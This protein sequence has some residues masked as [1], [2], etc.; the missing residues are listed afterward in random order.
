MLTEIRMKNAALIREAD[1]RLSEGFCAVTGETGAGKSV[2]VTSLA[3]LR[4]EKAPPKTV[5]EGESECTVSGLFSDPDPEL[6]AELAE[7]GLADGGDDCVLLS[8]TVTSDGKSKCRI[9]ASGV[10]LGTL[11]SVGSRLIQLSSQH[12]SF[13]LADKKNHLALIDASGAEELAGIKEAYTAAYQSYRRAQT[14]LD[15]T[16]EMIKS[17]T[18]KKDYLKTVIKQIGEAKLKSGEEDRLWEKYRA[19]ENAG[20]LA[21]AAAFLRQAVDGAG[22]KKGAYDRIALAAARLEAPGEA[23]PAFKDAAERLGRIAEELREIADEVEEACPGDG[24][25]AAAL[26]QKISDRVEL[27]RSLKRKYGG[28]EDGIIA[29]GE[30]CREEYEAALDGKRRLGALEAERAEKLASCEKAGEKLAAHR[31]KLADTLCGRVR[32]TLDFLD[33][34]KARFFVEF[35]PCEPSP[36]GIERAEFFISANPGQPPMPIGEVASGGE[37]SRVMLALK[38][39]LSDDPALSTLIFDEIDTGISGKTSRKLGLLLK[40]MSERVQIIAVTHS[41]QIASL[42]GEHFVLKK[43]TDGK[44]TV[45]RAENL[46]G[47]ARVEEIARILGG[48]EITDAVRENARELLS[49]QSPGI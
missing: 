13:A 31:K 42:A 15:E 26:M 9:N 32:E 3:L 37:L 39:V 35:T 4:G 44:E 2:F 24:E 1:M 16:R 17:A 46:D 45:S 20:K 6:L 22:G 7:A 34:E 41:A 25:N 11:K 48:I 12:Q 8:R 5:R 14:A 18:E 21:E 33:M 47:S 49:E 29:F 23:V 43:S 30:K 28:D 40:K 19:L 38:A 10:P 27:I 36:D